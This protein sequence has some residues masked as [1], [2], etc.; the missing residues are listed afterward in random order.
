[1]VEEALKIEDKP[2][3]ILFKEGER[4]RSLK[5][6]LI[7]LSGDFIKIRTFKQDFLINTSSIVKIQGFNL[8]DSY[9]NTH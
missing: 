6:S 5:G 8:G 9:E 1:M 3:K 2:V 4:L 7:G